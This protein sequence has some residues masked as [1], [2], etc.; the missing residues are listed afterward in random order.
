MR[1]RPDA[2]AAAYCAVDNDCWAIYSH[3][4]V[5]YQ[6]LFLEPSDMLTAENLLGCVGQEDTNMLFR[7][8][9]KAI[10]SSTYIIHYD[11]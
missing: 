1:E 3:T 4:P 9:H 6:I 2:A 7:T 11:T 5:T 10:M 8:G